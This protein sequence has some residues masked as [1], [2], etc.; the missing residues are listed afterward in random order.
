MNQPR[1]LA[2]MG[3]TVN[4]PYLGAWPDKIGRFILNFGAI[5]LFS[6][7]TLLLLEETEA[8]FLKNI[9]T[10]FVKRADRILELLIKTTKLIDADREQAISLWQTAKEIAP[11]R[12]RIAHNPVLPTWKPGSD[13][14]K[15]EP[16]ILGIPDVKQLKQGETSDSISMELLDRMIND[17][18]ELGQ[19]L[20]LVASKIER[21]TPAHGVARHEHHGIDVKNE[22]SS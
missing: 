20:H 16:D 3:V 11:W 13:Y 15:Q 18:V 10:P 6:Y 14:E 12:N 9:D 8:A 5:E 4:A 2:E 19:G 7:Q 17:L 21:N 22:S 1:G